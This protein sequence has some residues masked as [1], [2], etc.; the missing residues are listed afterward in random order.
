MFFCDFCRFA[1]IDI[2]KIQNDKDQRGYILVCKDCELE[3]NL[4]DVPSYPVNNLI[5]FYEQKKMD[6]ISPTII[7]SDDGS[8]YIQF[9]N[10]SL[11][12]LTREE[13]ELIADEIKKTLSLNDS[14]DKFIEN[15]NI[16]KIL[17]RF[18][19]YSKKDR[20]K[21]QIPY[22]DLRLSKR[23]FNADKRKWG[24]RCGN[25]SSLINIDVQAFY[26][27]INPKSTFDING[28]RSCSIDCTKVIIKDMIQNWLHDSDKEEYFYTD[29]MEKRI[30]HFIKK[31]SE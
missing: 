24:F 10:D 4:E 2:R 8:K 22:H 26:F 19:S 31:W 5:D 23:H 14:F 28:D 11:Q 12:L 27:S 20:S 18:Y 30:N 7:R 9:Q 13:L 29:D 3:N 21:F 25:C 6:P 1:Y 15:N 17:E 16:Q